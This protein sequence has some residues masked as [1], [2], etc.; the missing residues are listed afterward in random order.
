MEKMN[1]DIIWNYLLD[2]GLFDPLMSAWFTQGGVLVFLFSWCI[3]L[4]VIIKLSISTNENKRKS[5]Q[6]P[7]KAGIGSKTWERTKMYAQTFYS[8]SKDD[9]VDN[10]ITPT[11]GWLFWITGIFYMVSLSAMIVSPNR[12]L[13]NGSIQTLRS[14]DIESLIQFLYYFGTFGLVMF[15]GNLIVALQLILYVVKEKT[16]LET[17]KN[18]YVSPSVTFAQSEAES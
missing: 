16:E 2:N 12:I 4:I 15:V 3:L 13:T 17:E 8:I 18:N 1:N 11:V 6:V 10:K 5:R 9:L 7:K 14:N